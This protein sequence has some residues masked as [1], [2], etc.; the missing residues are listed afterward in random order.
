MPIS[1]VGKVPVVQQELVANSQ[2]DTMNK[3]SF[4]NRYKQK[5][6]AA[7]LLGL[8]G[9]FLIAMVGIA[10]DSGRMYVA[11]SELQN[12]MD[13]CA[14]AAASQLQ[15]GSSATGP[16]ITGGSGAGKFYVDAAAAYG[17]A[18]SSTALGINANRVFFQAQTIV[19]SN[20]VVEFSNVAHS[21]FKT[22]ATMTTTEASS[23][24][25]V[26]CGYTLNNVGLTLMLLGKVIPGA[27]AN[28]GNTFS[29]PAIAT[30][31]RSPEVPGNPTNNTTCGLF[32]MLICQAP[33][34]SAATN[35]GLTK[36]QWVTGAPCGNGNATCPS[37]GSGSFGW[38]E[39]T[40]VQVSGS[41][42]ANG[43]A[44]LSA[45][46]AG[47]GICGSIP[48]GS[49]LNLKAGVNAS[50]ESAWNSRFGVY[51]NGAGNYSQLD[52]PP[53]YTGYS[54][55]VNTNSQFPATGAVTGAF[56][57]DYLQRR[58]NASPFSP[59]GLGFANN[60]FNS[61]NSSLTQP[62]EYRQYGRS[63]RVVAATFV[64]CSTPVSGSSQP[65][66]V[67]GY[68]C[69]FL[70]SPYPG[71]GS[72]T[73]KIEFLGLLSD[74]DTPCSLS[75]VPGGGNGTTSGTAAVTPYLVR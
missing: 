60:A 48:V 40:G 41:G 19:P 30:A 12:A 53:D 75:G 36:N 38:L 1:L 69:F 2:G 16:N 35:F 21:N 31:S 54:Y 24:K 14:L 22:V 27:A 11:R 72:F 34:S 56:A 10:I 47:E 73:Q 46:V 65:V 5:G 58:Q 52:A 71:N 45:A 23:A 17:R 68:G 67:K 7:V 13:S 28:Y 37:A 64:D 62:T 55:N 66:T 61:Y 50:V 15:P 70:L 33:G 42:C 32:P 26:R 20:I 43:A 74:L 63:R 18:M 6:A 51:K 8:T 29:V 49:S 39:P 9:A 25:F 3:Q 44:C 57:S 4:G 59:T